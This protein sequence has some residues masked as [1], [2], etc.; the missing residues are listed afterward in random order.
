MAGVERIDDFLASWHLYVIGPLSTALFSLATIV[1]TAQHRTYGCAAGAGKT[2]TVLRVTDHVRHALDNRCNHEGFTYFY[3]N[4]NDDSRLTPSA[5]LRSF[6]RQLSSSA[7]GQA[8]QHELAQLY[9]S[10]KQRGFPES[11]LPDTEARHLLRRFTACYPQ[12]TL[13]FDALDDCDEQTRMPFVDYL[14]D[15]TCS[16]AKPIKV[17]ISSRLD[18]DIKERFESGPNVAITATEKADDIARFVEAE[19]AA[20]PQWNRKLS[21]STHEKIVWTLCE[22]DNGMYVIDFAGRCE[23]CK[24]LLLT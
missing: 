17:F 2:K 15:L 19:I 23:S 7:N 16:A 4:C 14:E 20:R 5:V 9:N 11:W 22:K 1:I 8:V 12:T 24:S 13:I 10:N 21:A 3:S 6:L 18:G